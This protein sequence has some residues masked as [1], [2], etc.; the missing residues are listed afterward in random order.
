M[1]ALLPRALRELELAQGPALLDSVERVDVAKD[2]GLE[3]CTHGEQGRAWW[4]FHDGR[5]ACREPQSD[6]RLALA[7]EL[8]QLL[9]QGHELIA[10][11]PGRRI[12]L[13]QSGARAQIAKGYRSGRFEGALERARIGHRL[14]AAAGLRAARI[15]AVDAPR[16]A[17]RMEWLAG[18]PL[19]LASVS[20]ERLCELG[21][22]LRDWQE[23]ECTLE[24]HG[25]AD[26]LVVLD[27]WFARHERAL[28]AAPA[29]WI[30]LR[31]EL[32]RLAPRLPPAPPVACHRDLHDKQILVSGSS[33]ALL[34]FD[35]LCRSDACLDAANLLAHLALRALQQDALELDR[36]L[37]AGAQA[38][39]EGLDRQDEPGFWLRL[40]FHQA[41]SFQRLA[42]VYALRPR[43]SR[44]PEQLALLARRCLEESDG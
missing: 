1:S 42:L 23:Q 10:W 36:R 43:W 41:A 31:E 19:D 3:V 4:R 38:L 34:D 44:L 20:P 37:D 12:V 9:S 14:C 15:E 16:Q 11:R 39:L 40:R 35:L 30:A 28:G 5:L 21:Q 7:R 6:A 27:D 32:Q 13:R 22:S 2:G 17:F 33:L 8:P 24:V 26:E 18:Q 25:A 29:D